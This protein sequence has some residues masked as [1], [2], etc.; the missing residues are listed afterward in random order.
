VAAGLPAPATSPGRGARVLSCLDQDR[1]RAAAPG[2][3]IQR[4]GTG[5]EISTVSDQHGDVGH[6]FWDDVTLL[7]LPRLATEPFLPML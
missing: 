2:P 5:R 6:H 3:A 7:K 4:A 1:T